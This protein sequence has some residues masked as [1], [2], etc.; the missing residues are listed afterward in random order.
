MEV[1]TPAEIQGRAKRDV[2]TEDGL[3][4]VTNYFGGAEPNN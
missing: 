2:E 4:R 1:V 3:N